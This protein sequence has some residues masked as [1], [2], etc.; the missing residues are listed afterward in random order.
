M[1]IFFANAV[2]SG[3]FGVFFFFSG[4][5]RKASAKAFVAFD[6]AEGFRLRF[7][8]QNALVLLRLKGLCEQAP[9][10]FFHS[11]HFHAHVVDE[12]F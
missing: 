2:F 3:K 12:I 10:A 5:S 11:Y 1:G 4:F 7:A 9:D 6:L 8:L